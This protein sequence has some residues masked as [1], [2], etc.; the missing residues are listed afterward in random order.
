M[1]L[2]DSRKYHLETGMQGSALIPANGVNGV[3]AI[4]VQIEPPASPGR[5]EHVIHRVRIIASHQGQDAGSVGALVFQSG[6]IGLLAANIGFQ[7]IIYR[8][9]PM[10]AS[11]SLGL[12]YSSVFEADIDDDSD[13]VDYDVRNGITYS[14]VAPDTGYYVTTG[15]LL[16]NNSATAYNVLNWNFTFEVIRLRFDMAD[17]GAP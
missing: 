6:W 11:N 15:A 12:L 13:F 16:S 4:P 9:K 3:S 2:L 1:K 8:N 17:S 10:R 5:R 7:W 14:N